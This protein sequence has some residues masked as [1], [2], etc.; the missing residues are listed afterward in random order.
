M[1]IS[2]V[3]ISCRRQAAANQAAAAD[4]TIYSSSLS[5]GSDA[6]INRCLWRRCTILSTHCNLQQQWH[7]VWTADKLCYRFITIVV[8]LY[9]IR[10]QNGV[11]KAAEEARGLC[12]EGKQ[13]HVIFRRVSLFFTRCSSAHGSWACMNGSEQHTIPRACRLVPGRSGLT[14]MRSTRS[15]WPTPVSE[16]FVSGWLVG[17]NHAMPLHVNAHLVSTTCKYYVAV[18]RSLGGGC[19]MRHACLHANLPFACSNYRAEHPQ[20]DQGWLCYSQAHHHSLSLPRS[21]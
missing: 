2:T 4:T 18:N 14:P 17:R 16:A 7:S 1:C 5:K 3:R 11:P 15:P 8:C 10:R 21:C 9:S 6:I 13:K 12:A 19:S 20:A